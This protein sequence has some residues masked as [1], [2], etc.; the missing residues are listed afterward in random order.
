MENA[1]KA[2][3]IAGAILLSIAI[4]GIGM[5]VYNMASSTI[6]SINMTDAEISTYNAKFDKYEGTQT[7]STVRAMLD[8]IRTHNSMNAEDTSKQ[9]VVNGGATTGTV[10]DVAKGSE[11]TTNDVQEG[12]TAANLTT[13]K[14]NIKSGSRYKVSFGYSTSGLIKFINITDPSAKPAGGGN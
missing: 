11:N 13:I 3:I 10:T 2:L 8:T 12:T 1:S 14:G 6:G 5:T 7:G 4:I 9:I